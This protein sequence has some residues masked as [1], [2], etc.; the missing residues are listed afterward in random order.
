MWVDTIVLGT[1][2]SSKENQLQAGELAGDMVN[3]PGRQEV[4]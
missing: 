1:S 4:L 3:W 2:D